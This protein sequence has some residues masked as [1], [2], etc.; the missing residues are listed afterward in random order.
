M[1]NSVPGSAGTA[2]DS[3]RL[4]PDFSGPN[5]RPEVASAE[6]VPDGGRPPPPFVTAIT[7]AVRGG[8]EFLITAHRNHQVCFRTIHFAGKLELPSLTC[9]GTSPATGT[10]S[11]RPTSA[12][13][14]TE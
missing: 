3:F 1:G 11:R 7:D 10:I 4:R 6:Q 5:L 2:Q 12:D 13:T 8:S 9:A 14:T